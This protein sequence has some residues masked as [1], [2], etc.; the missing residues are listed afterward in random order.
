MKR[1][2]NGSVIGGVCA[3]LAKYNGWDVGIVR[4]ITLL[5][6]L[7]TGSIAFWAYILMWIF[8]EEE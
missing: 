3:G 7:F 2:T 6:W 1:V 5:L 8:I 4:I